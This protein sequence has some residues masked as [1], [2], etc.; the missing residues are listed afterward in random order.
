MWWLCPRDFQM[1]W[2][3]LSLGSS[4]CLPEKGMAARC[5]LHLRVALL[6]AD[7]CGCFLQPA[8]LPDLDAPMVL[9][10]LGCCVQPACRPTR[11]APP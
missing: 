1:V 10:D 11:W 3:R 7:L 5:F 6:N 2:T 9:M 4:C 8:C